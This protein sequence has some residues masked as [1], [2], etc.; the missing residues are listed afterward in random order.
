MSRF[1]SSYSDL[2]CLG[3]IAAIILVI[4]I[5]AGVIWLDVVICSWI[6]SMVAV[7]MFGLP[8]MTMWQIFGIKVLIWAFMPV[9]T[10]NTKN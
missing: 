2:G 5:L 8:A 9:K 6:W 3:W 4:V 10:I 7:Q 1:S